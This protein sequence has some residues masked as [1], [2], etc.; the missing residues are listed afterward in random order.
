MNASGMD[1]H[2]VP[3]VRRGRA[4]LRRVLVVGLALV[5]ISAAAFLCVARNHI[6]SLWSLRQVPGTRMYV[7]DYY[8]GY[9]A[10]GLYERGVDPED[11]PGSLIRNYFPRFVSPIAEALGGHA[12]G[13]RKWRKIDHACSTVAVRDDEGHMLFGRN[14]DWTHDPCL[15]LQIH[16]TDGRSSVNM[17]DLHYLQL[18][19][20]RLEN[21]SLSN[22]TR[23]LLAPYIPMDGM[24]DRGLAI[25]CMTANESRLPPADPARPTLVVTT[26]MRLVLDYADTADEAVALM[27]RFNLDFDGVPCHFLIADRT[28]KSVVVEFVNGQI[29]AVPATGTWQV[30]TNHLLFGKSATEND[31]ACDRY[32]TAAARLDDTSRSVDAREVMRLMGS[33]SAE[34]RTM[35]TSLFNLT[36]GDYQIAYR[37]HYDNPF[38]DR[39]PQHSETLSS[40]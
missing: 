38:A 36:T 35:W 4:R 29:E 12:K 5:S 32:R 40:R 19:E 21:L 34:N 6:R 27:R 11:I 7:M 18:D 26:L 22:R 17:I 3:A 25:S 16:G 39:L 30:S 2:A 24:N 23:L 37:R 20:K 15:I 33:I 13:E 28:G 31:A 8:C 10:A 14:F 9:N 1:G